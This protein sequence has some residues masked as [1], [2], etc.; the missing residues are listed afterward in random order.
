MVEKMTSNWAGYRTDWAEQIALVA[1]PIGQHDTK[2]SWLNR[3]ARKTG[4]KLRVIKSLWYGEIT[5]P[6]FSVGLKVMRA[7]EQARVASLRLDAL[8]LANRFENI[9]DGNQ[10]EAEHGKISSALRDAA[11]R[12]RDISGS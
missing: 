10:H 5:D 11:L 2:E 4:I 9:A 12:L 1:G 6:K 7:A 3:A 8:A